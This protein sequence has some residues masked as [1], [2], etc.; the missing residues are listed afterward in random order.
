LAPVDFPCGG[1]GEGGGTLA[2]GVT[3]AV[4][5]GFCSG[6]GLRREKYCWERKSTTTVR[7]IIRRK[8]FWPPGSDCGLWYSA[9]F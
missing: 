1:M 4:A 8:F 7:A 6:G 3:V 5:C 9:K 2:C